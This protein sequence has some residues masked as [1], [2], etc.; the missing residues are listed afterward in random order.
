MEAIFSCIWSL[1]TMAGWQQHDSINWAT[2]PEFLKAESSSATQSCHL[3]PRP[4][5]LSAR[6]EAAALH[7]GASHQ[8]SQTPGDIWIRCL[9]WE[10]RTQ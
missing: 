1:L 10:Q 7:P 3:S 6:G 8:V 2:V 9:W 5:S 4:D